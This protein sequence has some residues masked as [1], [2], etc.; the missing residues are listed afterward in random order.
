M[1]TTKIKTHGDFRNTADTSQNIKA[2]MMAGK[3]WDKLNN[4]Q[5]E[6]LAC[7]AMKIGRILSGDYNFRDHW[8][9]IEGY[10][11]LGGEY[12]ATSMPQVSL[13][14]TRAL[15]GNNG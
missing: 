5:R 1:D 15:G 3:N 8:D 11:E 4:N 13:D 2:V 9:D 7:I 6:A 14:L 12:S 10:A